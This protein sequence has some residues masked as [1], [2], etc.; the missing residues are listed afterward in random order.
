MDA[1]FVAQFEFMRPLVDQWTRKLELAR[2]SKQAFQDV[3]DQCEAFFSQ[4]C[5]FMWQDKYREK[6]MG[7]G[8]NKPKFQITINKAFEL[9]AIF[10]PYLFWKYPHRRI[11]SP[12]LIELIPELFG[13]DEI[14]QF[15]FQQALAETAREEPRG[16][17]RNRLMEKYLNYSQR[18][19]PQG[20][21][22]AH[23]EMA[24]NDGLIRGRGVL[25]VQ[26]YTAPGSD[27]ML[28]GCF[29]ESVNDLFI[30]PDSKDPM[31]RDA[32]W[33]AIRHVSAD[34][35]LED[36]FRVPR[37]TFK[38]KG[39][40]ESMESLATN[41]GS[42]A[43]MHRSNGQSNDQIV[44]YEIWSKCGVG[45]RMNHT[46]SGDFRALPKPLH[47]AF[48]KTV[49]DYAYLCIAPN[50]PWPLNAPSGLIKRLKK[51]EE[52]AKLFRW[53]AANYGPEF[54]CWKDN[55]WP[56]VLLD[57]NKVGGSAWPVAPLA[58][59]LGELT[60]LNVLMSALVEQ[61]YENRKSYL[62]CL[63]SARKYVEQAL[64]S[65]DNPAFIELNETAATSINQA[66]QFLNRPEMN[67]DI[68][69]A[70]EYL[71]DLFD[72]RTGLTDIH[73][74]M[75]AGGVQSR[76][77]KDMAVK[78]EK[79]SIRP[80]KMSGDVARW[81]SEAAQLEKFLAGWVVEG[82]SLVPL[83][84]RHGARFWDELIAMEDPEVIVREMQAM[85]EASDVRRPNKE[86]LTANL[87]QMLQFL[88]P[89]LKEYAEVTGDSGPL[90]NFLET[91]GES[92]DQDLRQWRMGPW[93]PAA[94]PAMQEMQQ[95]MAQ[96]EQAKLQAD[97]MK[98]EMD[99]QK[100]Q[101]EI[102]KAQVEM[103]KTKI[104]A[105]QS[106]NQGE[107]EAQA[108]QLELQFDRAEAMQN[109]IQ[110]REKHSLDMGH[111][112]EKFRQEMIQSRN[113]FMEELRQRNAEARLKFAQMQK[114]GEIKAESAKEQAKI[115][116]Q[117]AKKKPSA[118]GSKA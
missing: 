115:K 78:E 70:I 68:L 39:K 24:I 83:L 11:K 110:D 72:K 3:G 109:L 31:L 44:W 60:A 105:M 74:A 13:A 4:S 26:G 91:F 112:N 73:Y 16:Q 86:R 71:M 28:T 21:L 52:V 98:S 93:T 103:E 41:V 80:E 66:I 59:A 7:K 85:V 55:R 8:I 82:R 113:K 57:F 87:Q 19:Q 46:D 37:G 36:L 5:G 2:K 22:A 58:P 17:F 106:M 34:W 84:G 63:S 27:H 29:Y 104:E 95:M 107:Q 32:K 47:D 61:G 96:L 56:V 90:N 97:V 51:D 45:S 33:M 43:H 79:A 89:V 50:I 102:Q 76:T 114:E 35:E 118:N 99:A 69:S 117:Q 1:D 12:D 81:M 67:K 94:D 15:E 116:A 6:Y 101:M 111:D 20:G 92:I 54:P 100:T 49:G 77:A 48:D 64:K 14:G 42:E 23:A 65:T 38:N 30:D 108:R 9:V 88:F 75:N 40:W 62:G 25:T 18:E 53:R 10:G